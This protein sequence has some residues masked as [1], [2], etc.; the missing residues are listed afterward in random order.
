MKRQLLFL[1]IVGLMLLLVAC[2]N[3]AD[4]TSGDSSRVS[5]N[6]PSADGSQEVPDTVPEHMKE[7]YLAALEEGEVNY[8]T[9]TEVEH[10]LEYEKL[11]NETYPGIKINHFAI[12]PGEAVQRY[13]TEQQAGN[14]TLDLT[15]A[16]TRFFTPLLERDMFQQFNYKD[17]GVES[18]MF[19][20]RLIKIHNLG[21]PLAYN[22]NLLSEDEVPKTWEEL[23]D[24]KWEGKIILE[25]RVGALS[26]LGIHWGEEKAHEYLDGIL[27]LKPIIHNGG[28]PTANALAA[29]E[30]P[31]AIGTYDY[32]IEEMKEEGAPVEWARTDIIPAVNY[33]SGV[34]K[35]APHPNAAF[36]FNIWLA[37][38]EGLKAQ[39][40]NKGVG[41]LTESDNLSEIGQKMKDA[42]AEVVT[43][44]EETV[45]LLSK[46][47]E[48]LTNK[49]GNLK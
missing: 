5:T 28:V 6:G 36:L 41:L 3:K 23:L 16:G 27:K 43:E 21:Y 10:I 33:L 17:Y 42:G 37:S 38:D 49:V 1:T 4:Q 24:P 31:L 8:W 11:F 19:D 13:I 7:L 45:E 2:G 35:D 29:G 15:D 14:N 48:D 18:T 39:E 47:T 34:V 32:R 46:L 30:A 40:N 12:R 9:A 26:T 20:D 44:S 22:T 25:N